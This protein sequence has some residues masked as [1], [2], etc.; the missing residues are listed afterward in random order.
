MKFS[1]RGVGIAAMAVLSAGLV[2]CGRDP[3]P[4]PLPTATPTIALATPTPT[5]TSRSAAT[6]TPT[7]RPATTPTAI[8]TP[9]PTPTA[10]PTPTLAGPTPTPTATLMPTPT[11]V[12]MLALIQADFDTTLFSE[13]AANAD[14]QGPYL[15]AG[16][17]LFGDSRRALIRFDIQNRLPPGAQVQSVRLSIR[18][19]TSPS[20]QNEVSFSLNRVVTPWGEGTSNSGG[21]EYGAAATAG[22]PT[23]THNNYGSS[24]WT[25]PGGDYVNAPSATMVLGIDGSII[26]ES[27]PQLLAD[28]NRWISDPSSSH[29]WIIVGGEA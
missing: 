4:T 9:T 22:D 20:S 23:W 7:P 2:T 1:I 19:S 6:P 12:P 29:G 10:S 28:V 27:T 14:A 21:G 15:Y 26:W 11:R 8:A 16:K 17:N 18:L 24:Q 13:V 25:T 3:T 5:A